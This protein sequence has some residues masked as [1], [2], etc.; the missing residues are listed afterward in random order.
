MI[1]FNNLKTYQDITW[2]WKNLWKWI[3]ILKQNHMIPQFQLQFLL[4]ESSL[5][6]IFLRKKKATLRKKINSHNYASA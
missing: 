3:L 4:N 1:M 5:W 2:F 6:I